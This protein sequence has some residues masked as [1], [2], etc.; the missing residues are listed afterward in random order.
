MNKILFAILGL[1]AVANAIEIKALHPL[2]EV[3]DGAD[4]AAEAAAAEAAAAEAAAAE[5]AAAEAAAAAT[6]AAAAEAAEE[7]DDGVDVNVSGDVGDAE[8][9][10]DA[11]DS[12]DDSDCGDCC[13]G[14]DVN[15]DIKF[16]VNV[17]TAEPAAAEEDAAAAPAEEAG[18]DA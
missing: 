8:V 13:G 5:A 1:T 6:E 17:S 16:A 14:N 9:D 15:I 3:D 7:S 18:P 2:D 10:V 12:H 4:A 11:D